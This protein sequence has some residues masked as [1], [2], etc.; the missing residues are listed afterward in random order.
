MKNGIDFV[1]LLL[2]L[3][4]CKTTKF[5]FQWKLFISYLLLFSSSFLKILRSSIVN[6]LR[7][8]TN[9][10]RLDLSIFFDSH[11]FDAVLYDPFLK[12]IKLNRKFPE[13]TEKK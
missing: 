12:K 13:E 5:F 2:L 8:A 4:F 6:G 9:G 11:C 3:F 10:L 1:E 7:L